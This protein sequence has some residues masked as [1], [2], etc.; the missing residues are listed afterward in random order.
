MAT[1]GQPSKAADGADSEPGKRHLAGQPKDRGT[2]TSHHPIE[3]VLCS[4]LHRTH[5]INNLENQMTQERI[6][7]FETILS[8]PM[9][10]PHRGWIQELL[11][12][13]K[14]KAKPTAKPKIAHESPDIDP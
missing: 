3:G 6:T 7:Y 5:C 9:A 4:I 10:E 1:N 14:G 13:V 2:A 12:A 11:E 8:K